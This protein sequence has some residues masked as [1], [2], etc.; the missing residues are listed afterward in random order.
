MNTA[1]NP[2]SA[3]RNPQSGDRRTLRSPEEKAADLRTAAEVFVAYLRM[4]CVGR[5]QA[6]PKWRVLAEIRRAGAKVTSR[7]YDDLPRLALDLGD[8]VGTWRKGAF[9]IVDREDFDAAAG[10]LVVRFELMRRHH[11]ILLARRRKRFPEEPLFDSAEC[12]MT[13]SRPS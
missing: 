9:F 12:G 5:D 1:V 2:Q 4:Y 7:E 3:I 13:L 8:D 6:R 10:N 11:D